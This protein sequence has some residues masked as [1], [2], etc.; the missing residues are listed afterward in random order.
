MEETNNDRNMDYG[1]RDF[2]STFDD[3]ILNRQVQIKGFG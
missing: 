3:T 2:V 1:S